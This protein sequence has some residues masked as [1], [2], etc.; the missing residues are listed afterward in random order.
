VKED[1]F[2]RGKV[3]SKKKQLVVEKRKFN[4]RRDISKREIPK[5]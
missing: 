4:R 1:F 3:I 2:K 5:K